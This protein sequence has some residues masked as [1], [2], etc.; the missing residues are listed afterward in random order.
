M[1]LNRKHVG[2]LDQPGLEFFG[3]PNP[4]F[5][6][7]AAVQHRFDV[8][9]GKISGDAC[10]ARHVGRSGDFNAIQK[11]DEP[12]VVV[13]SKGQVAVIFGGRHIEFLPQKDAVGIGNDGHI[14]VV[15]VSKTTRSGEPGR[16]IITR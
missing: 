1:H 7:T 8:R 9:S 4:L 5:G 16:G 10:D 6:L 13:D 2:A 15:S 3:I 11:S 12:V 14:V